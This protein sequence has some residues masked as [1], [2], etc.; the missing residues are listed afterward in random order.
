MQYLIGFFV[1]GIFLV[2]ACHLLSLRKKGKVVYAEIPE[3]KGKLGAITSELQ[4]SLSLPLGYFYPV[5]AIQGPYKRQIDGMWRLGRIWIGWGTVEAGEHEERL[6]R[7][8]VFFLRYAFPFCLCASIRW[9]GDVTKKSHWDFVFGWRPNGVP[10]ASFRIQSDVSSA[11][12][13]DIPNSG[14]AQS[15]N[16]GWR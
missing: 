2:F 7:N 13:Y 16:D 3:G 12:G 14:Q 9:S 10:G 11:A 5:L 8:G 1:Q 6:F 15:W 4:T